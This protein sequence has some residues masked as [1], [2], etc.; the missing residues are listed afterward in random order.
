MRSGFSPK[1]MGILSIM[2]DRIRLFEEWNYNEVIKLSKR[3][4]F[5]HLLNLM[6]KTKNTQYKKEYTEVM[7]K[8]RKVSYAPLSIGQKCR[9]LLIRMK[10]YG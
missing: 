8:M 9:L 3:D 6:Q 4:Y 10:I 5:C 1:K 7:E 2:E